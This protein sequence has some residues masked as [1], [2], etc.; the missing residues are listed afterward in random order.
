MASLFK[1][2]G[3]GGGREEGK[4]ERGKKKK[5]RIH[6]CNEGEHVLNLK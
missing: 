4:K 5:G 1:R 6:F 2:T 3:A